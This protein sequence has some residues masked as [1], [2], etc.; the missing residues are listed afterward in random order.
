MGALAVLGSRPSRN[1]AAASRS[2][3]PPGEALRATSSRSSVASWRRP[4]GLARAANRK[5]GAGTVA[6]NGERLGTAS[7]QEAGIVELG[8]DRE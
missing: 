2:A 7:V 6:G 5:H 1:S 4:V 3:L 8:H